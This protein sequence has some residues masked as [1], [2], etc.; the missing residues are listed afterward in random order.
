MI[1]GQAGKKFARPILSIQKD[2]EKVAGNLPTT[3]P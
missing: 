1:F 3:R 2:E